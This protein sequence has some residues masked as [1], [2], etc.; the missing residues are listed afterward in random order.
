MPYMI[1]QE[2]TGQTTYFIG[3]IIAPH[4]LPP[5]IRPIKSIVCAKVLTVPSDW[6]EG[7]S[8]VISMEYSFSSA[9]DRG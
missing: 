6:L 2:F 5:S 7:Y 3:L 1:L 8:S 9:V 4:Y